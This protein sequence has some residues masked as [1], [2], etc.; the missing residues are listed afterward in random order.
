MGTWWLDVNDLTSDKC[1]VF[2]DDT[3]DNVNREDNV[4]SNEKISWL[5]WLQIIYNA[6]GNFYYAIWL[7]GCYL[8]KSFILKDVTNIL[9]INGNENAETSSVIVC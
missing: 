4:I 6:S 3:G 5:Y 7:I 9:E 8:L 2:Y 1:S